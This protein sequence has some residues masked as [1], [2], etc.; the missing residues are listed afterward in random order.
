[1]PPEEQPKLEENPGK[2]VFE[3][4]ETEVHISWKD[5][6]TDD[7]HE[8]Y[9]AIESLTHHLDHD[10]SNETLSKGKLR[11]RRSLDRRESSIQ[12]SWLMTNDPTISSRRYHL[13]IQVICR[14]WFKS[15][16][17]ILRS[18]IARNARPINFETIL[19]ERKS[20]TDSGKENIS[21]YHE[22]VTIEH[23]GLQ[24]SHDRKSSDKLP[25]S[26]DTQFMDLKVGIRGKS[27]KIPVYLCQ[28]IT[29]TDFNITVYPLIGSTASHP[30]FMGATTNDA[31]LTFEFD[32]FKHADSKNTICSHSI[33]LEL[34][35][36]HSLHLDTSD[37]AAI[38]IGFPN[39]DDG[40]NQN[41]RG[42]PR[43]SEIQTLRKNHKGRVTKIKVH[44]VIAKIAVD[45]KGDGKIEKSDAVY[46]ANEKPT[47]D[48][49][50]VRKAKSLGYSTGLKV[51]KGP[52]AD[53]ANKKIVVPVV[54]KATDTV[55]IL[56]DKGVERWWPG[57][58]SQD[59]PK[60]A[61][62]AVYDTTTDYDTTT[63]PNGIDKAT[64]PPSNQ[65]QTPT[66]PVNNKK[67]LNAWNSDG[68]TSGRS[69]WASNLE[70][71]GA[72]AGGTA[73][74]AVTMAGLPTN[75]A[76]GINTPTPNAQ[77]FSQPATNNPNNLKASSA[78]MLEN[79]TAFKSLGS[80]SPFSGDIKNSDLGGTQG[81]N[82]IQNPSHNDPNTPTNN[83][84]AASSNNQ[85]APNNN[86]NASSND[87]NAQTNSQGSS[88][89]D[90]RAPS[91]SQSASNSDQGASNSGQS[92]SSNNPNAQTDGQGSASSNAGAPNNSQNA[93]SNDPNAQ[94]NSQGS[95]DSDQ[96]APSNDQNTPTNSQG[97]S[98]SDQG[99]S[100][101]G[102][103]ATNRTDS[104]KDNNKPGKSNT[105]SPEN[106]L[107]R[108][109]D[110][111]GPAQNETPA[112]GTSQFTSSAKG[113][114]PTEQAASLSDAGSA[115][116]SPASLSSS[117]PSASSTNSFGGLTNDSPSRSTS[118]GASRSASMENAS[119]GNDLGSQT[120][121]AATLGAPLAGAAGSAT[122]SLF[123][124][125]TTGTQPSGQ[126]M[127]PSQISA[128]GAD[129]FDSPG[130]IESLDDG[131][132]LDSLD[133]TGLNE[134]LE[135]TLNQAS[136][137]QEGFDLPDSELPGLATDL[138]A[139][140]ETLTAQLSSAAAIGNTAQQM[141]GSSFAQTASVLGQRV[142]VNVNPANLMQSFSANTTT[143]QASVVNGPLPTK[144]ST[145]TIASKRDSNTMPLLMTVEPQIELT[146]YA[147]NLVHKN[148]KKAVMSH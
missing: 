65:K 90:Q 31:H 59:N 96:R 34:A 62:P 105:N 64:N 134:T 41:I 76:G 27:L 118:M 35:R 39:S 19:L 142:H 139:V 77:N 92:A 100:H 147:K 61:T 49:I 99:A 8:I 104:T 133:N 119:I 25:G 101:S 135:N 1:M 110:S 73:A 75:A 121:Q 141:T 113:H 44:L 45:N 97:S 71:L 70:S 80:G 26:V 74:A 67:A 84:Q 116:S 136:L 94:T 4:S 81:T 127:E 124:S 109:Q 128:A 132:D 52:V 22:V 32:D 66:K 48:R 16:V 63:N 15:D 46:V 69:T 140:D 21:T 5:K 117:S 83:S 87:P 129:T 36:L 2:E 103:S 20:S 79:S 17:V 29:K 122:S 137:G 112:T 72:G 102:Q 18:W 38:E 14:R 91:N 130:S 56:V 3:I 10:L 55:G 40:Q 54:D 58:P 42:Y 95:S 68:P 107:S 85:G 30:A 115:A 7:K 33:Q 13:S 88:D 23:D 6:G 111:G 145:S 93:S 24:I 50:A 43:F 78:S 57:K 11:L 143:T 144:A 86:Q 98:N 125:P 53:K 9:D 148:L 47:I 114:A 51:I 89:S 120:V 126:M 146:K 12:N 82:R 131:M 106:D 123:N 28:L 108:D 37:A 138:E 60:E